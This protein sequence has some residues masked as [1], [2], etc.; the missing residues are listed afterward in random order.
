VNYYQQWFHTRTVAKS[1]VSAAV[2][3][4]TGAD[5]YIGITLSNI[6]VIQE[7][8]CQTYKLYRNLHFEQTNT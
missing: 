3:V 6:Q 5:N 4:L 8:H 2:L 7:S 1:L